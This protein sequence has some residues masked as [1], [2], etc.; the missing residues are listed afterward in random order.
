MLDDRER[1]LLFE[2]ER[3]LLAEDPG[4]V[5]SFGPAPPPAGPMPTAAGHGRETDVIAALAG[6]TLCLVLLRGPRCLSHA[7]VTRRL[8]GRPPEPRGWQPYKTP[9]A[10]LLERCSEAECEALLD[11]ALQSLRARR[12]DGDRLGRTRGPRL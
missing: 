8:T 5:R 6:L 4:F 10:Y 7:E 2:I 1:G 3:R 9:F 11:E 12:G